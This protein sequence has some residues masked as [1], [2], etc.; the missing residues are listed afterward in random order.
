[1]AS[2]AGALVVV[3]SASVHALEEPRHDTGASESETVTTESTIAGVRVLNVLPAG[4]AIDV[5]IDDEL[6]A[7]AIERGAVSVDAD[8]RSGRS[9]V[10]VYAADADEASSSALIDTFVTLGADG[11]TTL[12]LHGDRS[13]IA[14][15]LVDDRPMPG[16]DG[17][18]VRFVDLG[19]TGLRVDIAERDGEIIV[20]D[21][22]A[23]ATSAYVAV[24]PG[25]IDL[26]LRA[27]GTTDVLL[28]P[29]PLDAR[30]GHSYSIYVTADRVS[31]SLET[32]TVVDAVSELAW[33]RLPVYE[34][35]HAIAFQPE[36]P[37]RDNGWADALVPTAI[38]ADLA[39]YHADP[40][41]FAQT[42]GFLLAP[43]RWACQLY[44]LG[45]FDTFEAVRVVVP[46]PFARDR[47]WAQG[48]GPGARP[49]F[50]PWAGSRTP[51][52]PT[53]WIAIGE[54]SVC[55]VGARNPTCEGP[56]A[57]LACVHNRRY[58]RLSPRECR[59][60]RA[61]IGDLVHSTRSGG[62]RTWWY[63]F[64]GRRGGAET[65]AASGATCAGRECRAS[66]FECR[67]D[68]GEPAICMSSRDVL[69]DPERV[70]VP[71]R[72]MTVTCARTSLRAGRAGGPP[73]TT[74]ARSRRGRLPRGTP[75]VVDAVA[76]PSVSAEYRVSCP[77]SVRDF[78]WYRVREVDGRA[79]DGWI[80]RPLLR[81]TAP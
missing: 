55:Q 6:I 20:A 75:V 58:R 26:V 23:G 74:S 3:G 40:A 64:S 65:V 59:G 81:D 53:R 63:D 22:P 66:A 76:I 14:F 77:R 71:R 19:G 68:G 78:L 18:Q 49:M 45:D 5:L 48:D 24:G 43:D 57:D 38:T 34:C 52:E 29:P 73:D 69:L 47:C 10:R 37:Q 9:R 32:L 28:E 51:C 30:A 61:R 4:T 21:L 56:E 2:L 70:R 17:A 25:S 15:A 1:M 11:R 8:V 42:S 79:R 13:S 67:F 16:A 36:F 60:T 12:A 33:R 44:A 27:A 7:E 41:F 80:A 72:A 46:R 50:D 31:G 39:L 62:E 54:H 35:A